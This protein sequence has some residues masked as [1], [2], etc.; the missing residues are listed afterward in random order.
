MR[1]S[2]ASRVVNVIRYL[3]RRPNYIPRY[4]RWSANRRIT[5]IEAELPWIT[6]EAIDY[7]SS[8]LT[9]D[10]SVFEY[11]SGGSTLFFASRVAQVTSVEN[12]ESWHAKVMSQVAQRGYENVTV[13]YIPVTVPANGFEHSEYAQAV[14]GRLWDLILIDGYTDYSGFRPECFTVALEWIK[15]GGLIVVD[16][17]WMFPTIEKAARALGGIVFTGIGPCR[18]G[19]TNTLVLAK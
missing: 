16:D 12:D 7:I 14:A 13:H 9:P 5:P 1:G 2:F 10:S 15:P 8:K 6:W 4:L 11:G 17:I 3:G 19:V 18:L